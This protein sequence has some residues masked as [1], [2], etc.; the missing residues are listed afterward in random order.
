ME[1]FHYENDTL[2]AEKVPL[3]DIANQFGT[4]CYVYSKQA[5]ETSW[6]AFNDSFDNYP[7]RIC[8][9][10]KANS[11]LNI[12]HILA[13]LGSGFDIVSQGELERVLMAG[14]NPQ[15]IVFSGVGKSETEI[16]RA[17]DS[18]IFCFNV[19]STGELERLNHLAKLKSKIA[20][21]ALRIN[22]NIDPHTHPYIS[23]GLEDNKFGID[24]AEA[25]D[26]S[27]QIK[28][29]SNIKLIG[30]ACHIGSQLIDIEPFIEAMQSMLDLVG[31]LKKENISLQY[32]NFGGGLGVR[33]HNE[34]PPA[35]Y[36]YIHLLVNKLKKHKLTII[37]EP[38]RAIIANAGILLTRVEYVKHNKNK[39][40]AI[41]DAGMNDL[42]RPS[43]YNAW[44]D[45][46]PVKQQTETA[47]KM[48]D[49]VGPVCESADFLGK[50]RKLNI[51][52]GD[53]LAICSSGAYGFSMSSNYNSRPRA[54]EV[55]VDH[56]T[57]H[58]IRQRETIQELFLKEIKG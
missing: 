7:H 44:Q 39:N 22:P 16:N 34:T 47:D 30:V 48:Y 52:T 31:Q 42:L 11:N 21:I 55:L 25:I 54:A 15:T 24:I 58:V 35:I 12:L 6:R 53:L 14:G 19:E 10:V 17:L 26:I 2:F 56:D 29:M 50:N 43:L 32:F 4:P 20:Q 8:Y 18:H 28:T 1:Y 27:R 3:N 38:G 37:I 13:K 33:Y 40:F 45:I 23:T 46:L 51:D 5:I 9:A 36:D 49:I 41:V 57:V